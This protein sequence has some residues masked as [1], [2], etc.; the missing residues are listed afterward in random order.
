MTDSDERLVPCNEC[1][2]MIDY[3]DG[4]KFSG[5][6]SYRCDDCQKEI[7]EWDARS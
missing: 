4:H 2:E 6:E 7:D 1:G 5:G 3:L